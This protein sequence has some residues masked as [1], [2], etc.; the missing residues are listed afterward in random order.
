MLIA[1]FPNLSFRSAILSLKINGSRNNRYVFSLALGIEVNSIEILFSYR[2]NLEDLVDGHT[3][4]SNSSNTYATK[5]LA[6]VWPDI[7]FSGS[8]CMTLS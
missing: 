7:K 5:L 8:R 6:C 3:Y 4:N 2:I 1:L